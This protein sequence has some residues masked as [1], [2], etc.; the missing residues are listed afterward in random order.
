[1]VV[2]LLSLRNNSPRYS[3]NIMP[4][5]FFFIIIIFSSPSLSFS[6]F[7]FFFSQSETRALSLSF[8]LSF[9]SLSLLSQSETRALKFLSLSSLSEWNESSR[10][11]L[12]PCIYS[13]TSPRAKQSLCFVRSP[14]SLLDLKIYRD[15]F[16]SSST[17]GCLYGFVTVRLTRSLANR[18]FARCTW[19]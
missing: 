4:Y 7:S 12:S 14:P 19:A 2:R 18:L 10:I 8:H 13:I 3:R 16:R 9:L 6:P 5:L 17:S 1:M 15:D 11:S